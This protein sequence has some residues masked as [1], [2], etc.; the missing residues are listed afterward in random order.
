MV[1]ERLKYCMYAIAPLTIITAM[2]M[3]CDGYQS[4]REFQ[5]MKRGKPFRELL[6]LN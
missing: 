2:I 1:T 6:E 5:A 4:V 3:L